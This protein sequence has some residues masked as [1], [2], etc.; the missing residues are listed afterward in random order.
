MS[1]EHPLTNVLEAVLLAA[2]RPVT[3][4][5]MLELFEEHQRPAAEDVREAKRL[6][7][8][9][10]VIAKIEKPEALD[11]LGAVLAACDGA[12][13]ARGDL[14]VE[15]L[16]EEVP[17]QQ[18][19]IIDLCRARGKAVIVATQML[20]SMIR[21]PRPTRAEA[22]D[23]A[24]AVLDGTDAVMLSGETA[25]G[26]YPLRSVETMKRIAL[27][28]EKEI[29]LWERPVRSISTT[30]GVPDAVS[31]AAVLVAR[32]MKVGSIISMTQSGST[33]QMVSKHRPPCPI[34]GATPSV[35]TWGITPQ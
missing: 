2:G 35:R 17:L 18:K 21:N 3:V 24:N 8:S 12:M 1:E 9:V 6:A 25:K 19:R 23:V 34:L 22:S 4:E 20:D 5:Q 31:S 29:E 28:A 11:E 27:M 14:G 16:T 26:L 30:M 13:V 7:G 15:I 10:P 32:Q 33:A